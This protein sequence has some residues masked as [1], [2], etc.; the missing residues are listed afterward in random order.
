MYTF[1]S[2]A[3]SKRFWGFG[4]MMGITVATVE[5]VVSEA[6]DAAQ[7]KNASGWIGWLTVER[8]LYGLIL[9]AAVFLRL[10]A[11]GNQ[12]L[13]GLEATNVWP[14]WLAAT[15]RSVVE[16]PTPSSPLLFSLD[17]VLFWLA[18]GNDLG[19]RLLPAL[20]GVGL[21]ALTWWWRR[22]LG[23]GTALILALL[24]AVD[25][26]LTQFSRRADGT[27]FSLFFGWLTLTALANLLDRPVDDPAISK[28]RR[29]AAVAGGLLLVSG[30]QSWNFVV[31]LALFVW[32]FDPRGS[33][34][35]AR[36]LLQ[37]ETLLL[38]LVAAVLG[39]TAWLA[40]PAGLGLVSTSISLWLEQFSGGD[41]FYALRWWLLRLVVDVPLALV[42]GLIG[43]AR[44]W[45]VRSTVDDEAEAAR[46]PMGATTA[47]RGFITLWFCWGLVLGL[48][49]GRNPYSLP[50]I[51]LPLLV[52]AA[53]LIALLIDRLRRAA[54]GREAWLLLLLVSVLLIAAILLGAALLVQFT[55]D[56]SITRGMLLYVL[57]A[58]LTVVLYALWSDWTQTR[59]LVGLYAAALLLLVTL[60]SN[61]QLNQLMQPLEPDGF[62]A[63]ETDPDIERLAADIHLL[64]A[65]RTGDATEMAVEVQMREPPAE[66]DAARPHPLLG[67][68]L[69]NMRNLRWVLAPAPDSPP[70]VHPPLVVTFSDTADDPALAGYMGSQY[71]LEAEW[72]PTQLFPTDSPPPAAGAPLAERLNQQWGGWLRDLLRWMVYRKVRT[73]P[74]S[75]A[76]VL[77]VKN[78]E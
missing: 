33:A 39:A 18:G 57:L 63:A 76:V 77:W 60:S 67:W 10:F 50:M 21:V 20:A 75:E 13:N 66:G 46:L 52:A 16:T 68:Y 32:Q 22:W 1:I 35:R 7:R 23:R 70:G 28:W 40:Q 9:I 25:P 36:A 11:L 26:W 62:F 14:A 30:P 53:D 2:G 48:L 55:L 8:A 24:L 5:Q 78:E 65:Q 54:V 17:T 58:G 27:S 31:V 47:W 37:R 49:P 71:R 74:P 45:L 64:S 15:G 69:R 42:M 73:L 19:A 12:P 38:L 43:L 6:S 44:L 34:L 51:G 72:L 41:V 61:W 4:L 29:L 56:F 59:S 3:A